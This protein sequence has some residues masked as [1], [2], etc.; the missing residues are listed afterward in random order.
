MTKKYLV[1]EDEYSGQVVIVCET[2]EVEVD[3]YVPSEEE[4]LAA[5]Y[6]YR[7]LPKQM[8]MH[9]RYTVKAF[10][11][12]ELGEYAYIPDG[13]GATNILETWT[14][15][16]KDEANEYFKQAILLTK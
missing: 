1:S 7:E 15:F 11:H 13:D 6:L 12:Y 9:T 2:H 10:Y 8:E 14:T 16:D 4:L 3:V 5:K